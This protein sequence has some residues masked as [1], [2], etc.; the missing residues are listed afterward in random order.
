[1]KKLT[2]LLLVTLVS[3]CSQKNNSVTSSVATISGVAVGANCSSS[4]NI[5]SNM[6]GT[7]YDTSANSYNFQNQVAALLSVNLQPSE[8]GTVSA[9]QAD[10]T[11]VRFTGTVKLD[12]SGNVVGAQSKVTISIYDSIWLM[13]RYTNPN[14]QE[15]RIE[16]DPTL[17][18]G[19]VLSGQFDPSSGQGYLS[20]RDSYG[21]VRFTGTIDAQ[22][23]SG[24]VS[25]QNTTNVTG[26]APASGVLGQFYIQRCGFL[27]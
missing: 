14:E 27:Q 23:L 10:Q 9:A 1:M 24:Q 20:M 7:I 18:K 5:S 3:A 26:G 22:K 4:T 17:G 19:A 8:V 15:I 6:V 11:G 16:F 21:E 12:S 25:F 13:D 2:L